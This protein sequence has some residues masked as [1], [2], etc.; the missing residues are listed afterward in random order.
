MDAPDESSFT[1]FGDEGDAPFIGYTDP[2]DLANHLA[3]DHGIDA[4]D[5]FNSLGSYFSIFKEMFD[6]YATET[7]PPLEEI[8]AA[9]PDEETRIALGKHRDGT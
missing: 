2:I 3:E 1:V 9:A 4:L 5:A 6:K 7:P 8:I